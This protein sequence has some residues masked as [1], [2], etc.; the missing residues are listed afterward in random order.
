MERKY[1]T[2]VKFFPY[3]FTTIGPVEAAEM[4]MDLVKNKL[5]IGAKENPIVVFDPL[6]QGAFAAK[7]FKKEAEIKDISDKV[8]K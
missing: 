1:I 5:D 3:L 2:K 6:M 4:M 7:G 8:N